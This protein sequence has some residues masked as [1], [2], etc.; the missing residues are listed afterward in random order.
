MRAVD[1]IKKKRDGLKLSEGEIQF[2]IEGFIRGDIPDYQMTSFL[3]AVYFRGMDFEETTSL[4]KTMMAS[5]RTLDLS[6]IPNPK[7]D[8]HSTGGVGDKISLI[9]APLVASCGVVVPMIS[10]RALGHTGGTLDKLESIPGFSTNLTIEKFID[11]LKGVGV[12]IVGQTNDLVPADKGMYALRD[13]TATVD[14]I[15]LIASSIMSKKLAEGIDGLVLDVKTGNGAFMSE[16]E[17]AKRLAETMV[18][19]GKRM[20]CGVF[21]FIT[22]MNEPLGYAVGNAPEVYESHLALKGEG[23]PDVLELT[24]VLSSHM[25]ILA[26]IAGDVQ[27]ARRILLDSL[28]SGRAYEKWIEM[29]KAQ[30]GDPE[31]V[32]KPEFLKVSHIERVHSTKSGYLYSYNTLNIGMASTLLGAGR[33]KADD[34]VDPRVGIFLRKKR[35]DSVEKGEEIFE[36]RGND[37]KR[38]SEAKNLL[39]G[40]Y[41]IREELPEKEPIVFEIIS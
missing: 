40:S 25:L 3:M 22:N 39:E 7:I 10:G 14:S 33:A 16:Y 9:L 17:D 28:E 30:G 19:I 8:K 21:A 2:L 32:E 5:G 37:L 15:P 1:I 31:S 35:G 6:S 36:I 29:V 18:Q 13:A 12:A 4:T 20:G 24:L 27:S 34:E 26:G 23:P 41:E 11:I 38:V